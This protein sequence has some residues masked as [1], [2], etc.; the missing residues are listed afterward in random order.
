MANVILVPTASAMLALGAAVC[1]AFVGRRAVST[2]RRVF[3]SIKHNVSVDD[4]TFAMPAP[5]IK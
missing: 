2:S 5:I 1:D 4:R 3:T